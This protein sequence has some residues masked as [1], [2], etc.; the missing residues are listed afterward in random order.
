MFEQTFVRSAEG[1]RKPW[2]V[3][4]SFTGQS[5]VVAV[6]LAIPL[7]ETAHIA[8]TPPLIL[9]APPRTTTPPMEIVTQKAFSSAM[10]VIRPVF[11]PHFIGPMNV[12]AKIALVGEAP[13]AYS[14]GTGTASAGDLLLPFGDVLSP[15]KPPAQMTQ[16]APKAIPPNTKPTTVRVSNGVQRAMLLREVKPPYPPLAKAARISGVVRLAAVIAKDGTIQKLQLLSGPPLL[17]KAA[18]DA[19][20]QWRYKPTMLNGEP[21]EVI[22]EIEVNFILSN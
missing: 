8:W 20:Q 19:V 16:A 4:A 9:Y 12:P 21:V 7:V 2:P 17:V 6:M 15:I 13:P 14:T 10:P 3:A 11:R 1:A 18:M 5:I 22:T